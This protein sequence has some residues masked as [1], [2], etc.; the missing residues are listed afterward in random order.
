MRK[1]SQAELLPAAQA[2]AS[3]SSSTRKVS[4][5]VR[6]SDGVAPASRYFA[7]TSQRIVVKD[8]NVSPTFSQPLFAC[9]SFSSSV[10]TDCTA[11]GIVFVARIKEENGM[12]SPVPDATN[13]LDACN[14]NFVRKP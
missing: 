4:R 10:T 11:A 6:A 2:R 5:K 12:I 14:V 3:A 7:A 9:N 8:S 13:S 1:S